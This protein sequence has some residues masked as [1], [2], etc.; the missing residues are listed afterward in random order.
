MA[1]IRLGW[2]AAGLAVASVM[3]A[4]CRWDDG[5]DAPDPPEPDPFLTITPAALEAVNYAGE[6]TVVPFAMETETSSLDLQIAIV[7]RSDGLAEP[8]IQ[9]VDD[10]HFEAQVSVAPGLAVGTHSGQFEVRLCYDD[11]ASCKKPREGSPW[12]VSYT[13]KVLPAINLTPLR[14]LPEALAWT[15]YRGNAAHSAFVP[16]E[17]N[18]AEFTRRWVRSGGVSSV[19]VEEGRIYHA[20]L[21]RTVAISEDT[22]D[23]QW[24]FDA[25]LVYAGHPPAV[26]NGQVFVV[27]SPE[28]FDGTF[29][30]TLDAA[31]GQLKASRATT[32]GG[33][34]E[35]NFYLAPTP[36]ESDV[37]LPVD[38]AELLRLDGG[39]LA[40]AWS[41]VLTGRGMWTP[42]VDAAGVYAQIGRKF[43]AI[44]RATGTTQ[45][46]LEDLAYD[47]DGY[48]YLRSA[49]VLDGE[50]HAYAKHLSPY[51]HQEGKS[52]LVSVSLAD[53]AWR[54]R[55]ADHF[56]SDPIVAH[57]MVYVV[58]GQSV[59]G[60]SAETGALQWSWASPE[61][62][63]LAFYKEV[64]TVVVG[65]VL[66]VS[67]TTHTYA[68]DINTHQ[69]VWS[70]PEAGR[71]A[72]SDNGI[73][74]IA[75]DRNLT[76][77][78][79]H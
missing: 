59:E 45:W 76:A 58:N 3:M 65:Q 51:D 26:A 34:L 75:S 63:P 49:A 48:G 19:V 31:T 9:R 42:T 5:H 7:D 2:R 10:H 44:D 21:D 29:I 4:A 13:F 39:T 20:D 36:Y 69:Q 23:V 12:V 28:V 41:N 67:A 53:K 79:L 37:Y 71:L 14:K 43:V 38:S 73:L 47:D 78:N 61:A 60:R 68:I 22:G 56:S 25:G 55:V 16:A 33:D 32:P 66:F 64:G 52:R 70:Y 6:S 18:P 24:T 74:Y 35:F 15:T 11:T 57:G 30:R 40:P 72:V 17:V 27:T 77:I 50:G 46:S 62:F 54:W 1:R 8:F